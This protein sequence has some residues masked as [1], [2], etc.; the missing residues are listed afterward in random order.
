MLRQISLPRATN[1]TVP[2]NTAVRVA[3]S[4]KR[5]LY[6][7]RLSSANR[8]I[9]KSATAIIPTR[10]RACVHGLVS[11]N[12]PKIISDEN[13]PTIERAKLDSGFRRLLSFFESSDRISTLS[14]P[15]SDRRPRV[16]WLLEDD[17]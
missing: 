8:W 3:R 17:E 13:A 7:Y 16:F 2:S 14:P 11:R 12:P 9:T 5:G 1:V 10:P 15:S 6:P 4:L